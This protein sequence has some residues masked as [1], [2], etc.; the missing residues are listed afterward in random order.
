YDGE[1]ISG[2]K[3]EEIS[4]TNLIEEME[5]EGYTVETIILWGND[6]V[7]INYMVSDDEYGFLCYENVI[8]DNKIKDFWEKDTRFVTSWKNAG[9]GGSFWL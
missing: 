3:F 1:I 2:E 6:I 7:T 4:G 9:E 5:A 8:W